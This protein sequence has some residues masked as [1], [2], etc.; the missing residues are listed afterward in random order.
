RGDRL[1]PDL[2]P[3]QAAGA[4]DHRPR[5]PGAARGHIEPRRREAA[6]GRA[7]DPLRRRGRGL[8]T[9]AL[10]ARAAPAP[11]APGLAYRLRRK[12]S[13]QFLHALPAAPNAPLSAD[14]SPDSATLASSA[15]AFCMSSAALS[16][17]A[18]S[19]Q[20]SG[21]APVSPESLPSTK[22]AKGR[23]EIVATMRASA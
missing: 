23:C 17:L 19:F 7:G 13:W 10:G 4:D 20:I 2:P 18:R 14:S 8:A 5:P 11:R 12:S 9:G 15:T 16:N 6:P 1:V 21:R 22:A 3:P